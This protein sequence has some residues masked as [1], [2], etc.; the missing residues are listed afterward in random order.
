MVRDAIPYVA[1]IHSVNE[2]QVQIHCT[3]GCNEL[4]TFRVV[5]SELEAF[6]AGGKHIQDAMPSLDADWREMF[7]TGICPQCFARIMPPEEDE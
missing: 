4:K 2:A 7:L 6:E 3:A 1:T 5:P